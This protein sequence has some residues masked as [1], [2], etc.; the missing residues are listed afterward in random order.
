MHLAKR[1]TLTALL[2]ASALASSAL[3][4]YTGPTGPFTPK[5]PAQPA[6]NS[7]AE[8][9]KQPVD[10]A[11]VVVDGYITRRIAKEKY[12]LSDGSSEIRV[13]INQ[14]YLPARPFND[15][16]RVQIR[17]VVDND[18]RNDPEIDAKFQLILHD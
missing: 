15:K 17:G 13:E 10:D 16:S 7:I 14:K 18:R 3:A 11:P 9:L 6:Y 1:F 5:P 2:S 4:Q 8:V 12:V